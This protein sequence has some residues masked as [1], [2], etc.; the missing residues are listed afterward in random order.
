MATKP[1]QTIPTNVEFTDATRAEAIKKL[2]D[3]DL[4]V[5]IGSTLYLVVPTED[6][7]NNSAQAMYQFVRHHDIGDTDYYLATPEGIELQE[8]ND[9][10]EYVTGKSKANFFRF[11]DEILNRKLDVVAKREADV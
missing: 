6:P 5:G 1:I 7:Q 9:L 10:Y 4:I 11:T 3:A 2:V 8:A